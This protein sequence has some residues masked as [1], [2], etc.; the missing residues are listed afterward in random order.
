MNWVSKG[1]VC[2]VGLLGLIDLYLALIWSP[3]EA[4]MGDL[5]R[6]MYFHVASAWI[7]LISFCVAFGAAVGYLLTRRQR[8]DMVLVAAIEIGLVYTALT[9]VTGALWAK[10]VWNAWWTWDPRLTT[11]LILWFLF[12]GCV[13]LR[14]SMEDGRRR[15]VVTA[16]YTVVA[17]L[18]VPLIHLS[19]RLWRSIHPDLVNDTGF[20]MPGSMAFTLMFGFVVFFLVY[21]LLLYLRVRLEWTRRTLARM[22]G[23]AGVRETLVGEAYR[24]APSTPMDGRR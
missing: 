9:L 14:A 3:P 12:I 7:A 13:L 21:V 2:L 23:Q 15:A 17:F 8:C 1:C 16:V 4:Q 19:V 18:D 10:P 6:I 11:T 22:R 24:T 5:V 20:H